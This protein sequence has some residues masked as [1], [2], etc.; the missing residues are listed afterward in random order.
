MH[1]F[2]LNKLR[3]NSNKRIKP[4]L[5]DI[6]IFIYALSDLNLISFNFLENISM[7]LF[8]SYIHGF[9]SKWGHFWT[10]LL[11][12]KGDLNRS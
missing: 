8:D 2:N 6:F 3:L 1:K 7:A 9:C 4:N 12:F 5:V 10:I 11:L